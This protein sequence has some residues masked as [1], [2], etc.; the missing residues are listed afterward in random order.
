MS[1]EVECSNCTGFMTALFVFITMLHSC[2]TPN[3]HEIRGVINKELATYN[4]LTS[5]KGE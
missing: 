4:N 1:K 2:A 5:K 3:I